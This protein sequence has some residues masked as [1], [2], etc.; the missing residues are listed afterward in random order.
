[1][2]VFG[3]VQMDRSNGKNGQDLR[4]ANVASAAIAERA[5][6]EQKS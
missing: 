4:V 1:M 2:G 5:G 6:A 3:R